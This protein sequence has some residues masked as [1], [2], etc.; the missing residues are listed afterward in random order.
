MSKRLLL[1]IAAAVA[2]LLVTGAG[3]AFAAI[4]VVV[5][6]PLGGTLAE[7]Q[8]V[9]AGRIAQSTVDVSVA[10]V[11][12]TAECERQ[13]STLAATVSWGDGTPAETLQAAN[14][15]SAGS[16][17]CSID[18]R[19]L[20]HRYVLARSTPY[21]IVV[22]VTHGGL[23]AAGHREVQVVDAPFSGNTFPL[24]A[25]AGQPLSALVA[26]IRDDNDFSSV[27][28]FSA[29]I[30]WG[31]G[32][33]PTPATLTEDRPGR[34]PATGTHTYAQPGS[35]L[36]VVRVTHAGVTVPLQPATATVTG[37]APPI[38]NA[39]SPSG[40]QQAPTFA[41]RSSRAKLSTLRRRGIVLR[42]GLGSFRGNSLKLDVRDSRNGRT[43]GSSTIRLSGAKVVDVGRRLVDVTW[44]PSAKLAKRLRKGRRY[45]LR[46]RIGTTTVQRNLT[47]R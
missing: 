33:A 29:T 47:L 30:D 20:G 26:E 8:I 38:V 35:F 13:L 6:S 24:S 45:G 16:G 31:D 14:F 7:G 40:V 46:V 4:S 1:A 22:T 15:R 3:S 42:L 10:D 27:G 17:Q 11:P 23:T 34:F 9:P 37:A 25:V 41:L 21:D 19:T 44:K 28:S 36:V 2:A 12:S 32:T 18:L 5:D 43:V 39:Q